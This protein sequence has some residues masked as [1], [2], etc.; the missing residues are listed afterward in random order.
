MNALPFHELDVDASLRMIVEGTAT[1]TGERFFAALVENLARA[2]NTHGAWVTEYIE[3]QRR[4]RA[5]AFWMGGQWIHGWEMVVD[6]TPCEQVVEQRC[7][8]HIP[9]NLLD[10]YGNDPD[11]RAVGAASYMGMPLLDLDGKVLGHLAVL[12]LRPMP[13]E[14]R[15]EA[16]FQIFAARAAAELRRLRAEAA[17][18][19]REEKLG[20]LVNS[21]MDAI[22]ELDRNLSVNRVNAAA[23]KVFSCSSQEIVGQL[24]T[25]FLSSDSRERLANLIIELDLRPEGE[26]YTWIPGGLSAQSASGEGFPA[27][28]TL[29]RFDIGREPFYT[30]ILRNVN[31]RLK[32][33]QKI[34]SLTVE[35]EY[36]REEIK[37]LQ[38]FDEIVGQSK[39]LTR[40]LRDIEEVAG[41]DANVLILGETGTGKELIARAIHRNSRRREKPLIKVNCAAMPGTLIES[42]LFGHEQGAFTGATKKREGRF[43]LADGGTIFLDEIGEL[44]VEL[45]VKLLRVLQ[46][47]EFEP[48][49]SSRTQKVDARVIAATNRDLKQATREGKFREDLYY[50]LNVFPIELPPLRERG[51]DIGLLAENF[52][53]RFAQRMGRAIESLSEDCIRRLKSY[54]WPG[55]VR[56]LQNVIERAVIT[57]RD[58]R[59]NLDRA[60][61]ESGKIS[62]TEYVSPEDAAKRVRTAK[63][64]DELERSNLIAALEAT[65]WRVAGDSGAAQLL[66]MKP[67]TLSSRM[68]ALGIERRRSP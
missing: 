55:N 42:E 3:E 19:E 8:I 53:R 66:G 30:L 63:E 65:G 51:D 2:L 44:P 54:G 49:G 5:L 12:D 9:D 24:F 26:R 37:E 41:T 18:R 64:L 50:R 47:G 28:A 13:K 35:A 34:R 57:S 15:A 25:H 48:V 32:A 62:T 6:G 43:A 17:V 7:L 21:A 68:K 20:R 14:P 38:S 29:S 33:Q 61:P 46:E 56:E 31:A 36:L 4:L 16:L 10:I 52:V 11:V 67:T 60:L 45:Q 27:E 40:V 1:E 58:G 39:P 59:L 23:E 22:I